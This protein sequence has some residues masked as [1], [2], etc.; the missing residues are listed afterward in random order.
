MSAWLVE[1]GHI[2]ALVQGLINEG[3]ILG[4]EADRIGELLWMENH[5]SLNARYRDP[6]PLTTGY[7]FTGTE[8]PLSDS[9]LASLIACYDYQSCEHG[10]AWRD[11]EAF[12]LV[13][14]LNRRL[15]Q[16]NGV[17]GDREWPTKLEPW[18]ISNIEEAV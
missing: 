18:G 10:E 15:R 13:D 12:R 7:A 1:K 9:K 5:L 8:S 17:W 4:F 14:R 2:D 3:F 6:V 11:S 16:R